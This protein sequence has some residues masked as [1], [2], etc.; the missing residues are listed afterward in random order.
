MFLLNTFFC[1][2]SKI[3]PTFKRED[4]KEEIKKICIEEFSMDNV[5]VNE[6]GDTLFI[7][8]PFER[9][10]NDSW[11]WRE[12]II[13]KSRQLFLS[14]SRVILSTDNPPE[15]YVVIISDIGNLGADFVQVGY[16]DDLR[17]F[18]LAF[19]SNEEFQGRVLVKSYPNPYALGDVEGKHLTYIDIGFEEFFAELVAQYVLRFLQEN[20]RFKLDVENVWGEFRGKVLRI[21]IKGITKIDERPENIVP[22]EKILKICAFYLRAYEFKECAGLEIYFNE[23]MLQHYSRASIEKVKSPSRLL[24]LREE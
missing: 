2:C 9:V 7:Y 8:A 12:D 22:L 16:I 4:I 10:L 23:V 15:F 24:L 11:E 19:I 14:I 5:V 1:A 3:E 17:K 18:Y 13:D 20:Y 21:V 6:S